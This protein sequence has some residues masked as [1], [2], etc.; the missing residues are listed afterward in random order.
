MF[1]PDINVVMRLLLA[2]PAS[3][4][5]VLINSL[6]VPINNGVSAASISQL[7]NASVSGC[8]DIGIDDALDDH[9]FKS[10]VPSPNANLV[11]LDWKDDWHEEYKVLGHEICATAVL[12]DAAHALAK[13]ALDDLVA[14]ETF[15][16]KGYNQV[17]IKITRLEEG[18]TRQRAALSIYAALLRVLP[19]S[20]RFL[21]SRFTFFKGKERMGT[22]EFVGRP[23]CSD[24]GVAGIAN[25]SS[26][27]GDPSNSTSLVRIKSMADPYKSAN[28]SLVGETDDDDADMELSCRWYG[29]RVPQRTAM[30]APSGVLSHSHIVKENPLSHPRIK[31]QIV[32]HVLG[33]TISILAIPQTSAAAPLW[34][35]YWVIQALG[36]MPEKMADQWDWREV[37]MTVKVDGFPLGTISLIK[38]TSPTV[39]TSSLPGSND[40]SVLVT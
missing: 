36:R 21:A 8:R 12:V 18:F 4:L 6:I 25:A 22:I 23:C 5:A 33:T 13:I 17:Q 32:D 10:S 15:V 9:N 11:G 14:E 37:T 20:T 3:Y 26:A 19:S 7:V 30:L 31:D 24:D 35:Y 34:S 1:P 38:S 29:R 28:T 16:V 39:S 2:C 27:Q 40:D